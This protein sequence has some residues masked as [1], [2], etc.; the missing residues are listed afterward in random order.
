MA[1]PAGAALLLLLQALEQPAHQG[2]VGLVAGA[3]RDDEALQV[4]AQKREVADHVEYLVPGAFV[5]I[6]QRV[7]DHA[8]AA[9]DQEI[10]RG[11]P[12]ADAGGAECMG[13][14]LE[15]EGAAGGE[16]APERLAEDI[17][18]EALAC[19]SANPGRSRGDRRASARRP[20]PGWAARMA[21]PSRT[22]TERSIT[23][24][25]RSRSCSTTPACSNASTNDPARAVAARAFGG[26]DLDDGNCR[27]VMPARAAITCSIIS[28][29]AAPC[30]IVVRRC[31]GTT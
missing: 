29:W 16:L 21:S 9:E 30:R 20:S 7:A 15:E 3:V 6:A 28:T 4:H 10:G 11:G 8:V 14:G 17:D 23:R 12:G 26:V 19:R 1:G 22:V 31:D 25:W 18:Q 13:L 5:G 24:A 27:S 2:G